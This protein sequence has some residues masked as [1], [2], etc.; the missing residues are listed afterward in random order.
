[1]LLSH[2]YGIGHIL[3]KIRVCNVKYFSSPKFS[4]A[5]RTNK[6]LPP[7]PIGKIL[8]PRRYDSRYVACL[9]V[10]ILINRYLSIYLSVRKIR[11]CFHFNSKIVI[12]RFLLLHALET[13]IF[14]T[15]TTCHCFQSNITYQI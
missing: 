3:K 15:L 12:Y 1:M 5:H 13:E 9:P 7:P 14:G 6:S 11:Q 4:D 8:K 10:S 2:T